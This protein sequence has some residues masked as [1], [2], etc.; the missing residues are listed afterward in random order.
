MATKKEKAATPAEANEATLP[1]DGADETAP[2]TTTPPSA[3]AEAAPTN[4]ADALMADKEIQLPETQVRIFLARVKAEWPHS[5]LQSAGIVFPKG[6][7]AVPIRADIAELA[8]L[9]ANPYLDLT[10]KE[11]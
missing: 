6:G 5:L 7:E 1:A 10:L 11:D 3:G 2:E 8:E 9:Q 4:P